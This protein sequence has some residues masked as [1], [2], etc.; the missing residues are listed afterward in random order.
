M[1][2]FIVSKLARENA[3]KSWRV[4]VKS[5]D[6]YT[7]LSVSMTIMFYLHSPWGKKRVLQTEVMTLTD[8]L[9]IMGGND[10]NSVDISVMVV[11]FVYII[12]F[13]VDLFSKQ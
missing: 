13:K 11:S 5:I 9:Y 10:Q 12:L 3:D 2:P 6:S 4:G 8:L 7:L 1:K